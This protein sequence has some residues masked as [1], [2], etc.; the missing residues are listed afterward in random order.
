MYHMAQG[1]FGQKLVT[2]ASRTTVITEQSP[3]RAKAQYHMYHMAQGQYGQR[4][5]TREIAD[6]QLWHEGHFG[7]KVGHARIADH[8]WP[9]GHFGH[10]V[11]LAREIADHH[12]WHEGHFGHKVIYG[13]QAI[14][15]IR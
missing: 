1:Q 7:H 2:Q 11:G 15:G 8:L 14:L 4:L 12:L 13:T 6:H 10:K 3:T 9:E 5:V